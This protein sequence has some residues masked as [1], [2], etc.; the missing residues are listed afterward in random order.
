MLQPMKHH[1]VI[2]MKLCAW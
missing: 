1:S 2:A